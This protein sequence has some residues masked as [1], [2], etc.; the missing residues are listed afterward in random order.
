MN[1]Y[2]GLTMLVDDEPAILGYLTQALAVRGVPVITFDNGDKALEY[3]LKAH[4]E[5][6][7][8]K[9][10]VIDDKLFGSTVTGL[11]IIR[12][13]REVDNDCVII[14]ISGADPEENI[15]LAAGLLVDKFM[16]KP[17]VGQ[18]LMEEILQAKSRREGSPIADAVKSVTAGQSLS[19]TDVA[20]KLF[21]KLS[22]LILAL[23]LVTYIVY[24]EIR[25][26][27][28]RGKREAN[29][30]QIL[31]QLDDEKGWSLDL[32]AYIFN[33]TN[34]LSEKGFQV[35]PLPERKKHKE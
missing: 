2:T 15:K 18:N 17:V 32:Q 23:A 3:F 12:K 28:W 21:N 13:V 24:R 8:P 4:S 33:L 14:L 22:V 26:A 34:H 10:A 6:S 25:D 31:R 7:A 11:G 20:N 9:A 35:E 27:E 29:E 5:G 16:Q 19:A 30:A 1:A